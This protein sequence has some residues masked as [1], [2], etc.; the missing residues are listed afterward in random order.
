[1]NHEPKDPRKTL[2]EEL[3]QLRY[4]L[5]DSPEV[6][7]NI[8]ML[9]EALDDLDDPFEL[10]IPILTEPLLESEQNPP[11]AASHPATFQSP[12]TPLTSPAEP[13][14]QPRHSTPAAASVEL[15]DLL[16]EL[17]AEYL[18]VLE[19]RLREKLRLALSSDSREGDENH[20]DAG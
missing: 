18:P 9:D 12:Q 15:E 13:A 5:H 19:R 6:Q 3:D 14:D 8:P 2:I 16:D 4:T 10:D 20:V 17:I 7:Q 11:Q 1:M